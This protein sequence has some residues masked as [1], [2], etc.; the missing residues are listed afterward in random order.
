M[1][2]KIYVPVFTSFVRKSKNHN[3]SFTVGRKNRKYFSW[4]DRF[5]SLSFFRW[6]VGVLFFCALGRLV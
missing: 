5:F 4:R 2:V 6:F 1:S 3:K